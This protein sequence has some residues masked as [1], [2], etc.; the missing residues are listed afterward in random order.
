MEA[1]VPHI[2]IHMDLMAVL[3]T[4]AHLIIQISLEMIMKGDSFNMQRRVPE[5]LLLMW[6]V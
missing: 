6:K 2:E 4:M 1:L 5:G 3:T